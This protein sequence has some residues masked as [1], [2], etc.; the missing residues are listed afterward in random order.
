VYVY[1]V[2]QVGGFLDQWQGVVVVEFMMNC[3]LL[4]S[5]R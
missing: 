2:G 5:M 4:Q 1:G 3:G